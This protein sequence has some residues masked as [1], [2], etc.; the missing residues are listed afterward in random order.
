MKV[1]WLGLI[2]QFNWN[3]YNCWQNGHAWNFIYILLCLNIFICI[4]SY[5]WTCGL[6]YSND[7]N[8]MQIREAFRALSLKLSIC[9]SYLKPLQEDSRFQIHV[10]TN[11]AAFSTFNDNV[12]FEVSVQF[13]NVYMNYIV[14]SVRR[15]GTFGLRINL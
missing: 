3:T 13:I 2:I 15:G 5:I 9:D 4:H 14:N 8:L 12:N 10:H 1:L 11:E 6:L 7:P